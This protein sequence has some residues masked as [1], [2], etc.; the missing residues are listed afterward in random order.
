[1]KGMKEE[2]GGKK[3]DQLLRDLYARERTLLLIPSFI[4]VSMPLRHPPGW[5]AVAYI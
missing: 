4:L 3:V 5:Y 1:M 2:S